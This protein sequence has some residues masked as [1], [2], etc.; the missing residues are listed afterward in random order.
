MGELDQVHE[1]EEENYRQA[2]ALLGDALS[3]VHDLLDLYALLAE[4]IPGSGIAHRDEIVSA[5]Q[6]LVECRYQLTLGTL[7]TLRGHLTDAYTYARKA[8]ELCA[9]AARVKKHPHLAMI[10]LCAADDDTAYAR[11]HE[12][13]SP[14]KLFPEDHA[15]LGKLYDRYDQC[16][17]MSH[18]SI[19]SLSRQIEIDRT[20]SSL[21]IKFKYFELR[22]NDASEPARTFLWTVD[23]HFGILRIFEEVLADVIA[24]D[25]LKWEIRQNAVG[26]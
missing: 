16:S 6:F 13:F 20:T 5:A 15:L 4:R 23:T 14:G 10:W 11:Y 17:K 1:F 19:Y 18:P 12:K 26:S 24:R 25:R 3:L 2:T 7:A 22:D 9:F 21:E 8:I